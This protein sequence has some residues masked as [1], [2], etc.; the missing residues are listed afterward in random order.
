MKVNTNTII[1]IEK[2]INLVILQLNYYN[3]EIF[4]NIK[5]SFKLCCFSTFKLMRIEQ[6]SGSEVFRARMKTL[7]KLV[8]Y[9][10]SLHGICDQMYKFCLELVAFPPIKSSRTGELM[11]A[12]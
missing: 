5:H 3:L 9:L 11:T 2:G 12:E 4:I 6:I 8:F 10:F 1:K 7:N